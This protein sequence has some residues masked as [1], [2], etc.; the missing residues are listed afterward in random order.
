MPV[1]DR[2]GKLPKAERAG[3]GRVGTARR[4]ISQ[5]RRRKGYRRAD[6]ILQGRRRK[7]LC[8]LYSDAIMRFGG[9]TFVRRIRK[10]W[11]GKR[12]AGGWRVIKG[13]SFDDNNQSLRRRLEDQ[14]RTDIGGISKAVV[15]RAVGQDCRLGVG[16]AEGLGGGTQKCSVGALNIVVEA[17]LEEVVEA[18]RKV[19]EDGREGRRLI[20]FQISD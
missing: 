16:P 15:G 20:D 17:P 10:P 6:N 5:G 19:M 7:A 8:G 3:L 11:E 18:G 1:R 9:I 12:P 13:M 14:S 4:V 2:R